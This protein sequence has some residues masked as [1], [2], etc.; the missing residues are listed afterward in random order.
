VPSS[1]VANFPH[2]QFVTPNR[3]TSTRIR[4][5]YLAFRALSK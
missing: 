1:L 3:Q 2:A 5:L 4:T